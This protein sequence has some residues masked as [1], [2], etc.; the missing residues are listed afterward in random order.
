[1]VCFSC[2]FGVPAAQVLVLDCL[3]VG[4]HFSHFGSLSADVS[5]LL[6]TSSTPLLPSHPVSHL[7]QGLGVHALFHICV[8]ATCSHACLCEREGCLTRLDGGGHLT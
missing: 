8:C 7:L 6:H 4:K 3:H 1:L 2:A 5:A